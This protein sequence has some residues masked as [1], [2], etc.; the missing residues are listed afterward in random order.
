MLL[1][2]RV[3]ASAGGGGRW[4]VTLIEEGTSKRGF[5]TYPAATLREAVDG[6]LFEMRPCLLYPKLDARGQRIGEDHQGQL[7]A[8]GR[9]AMNQVGHYEGVRWVEG[10]N[11]RPGRVEGTLV[12]A[13]GDTDADALNQKL[14]RLEESGGLD[15]LGLSID[16]DADLTPNGAVAR[17]YEI[18]SVDVVTKPGMGGAFSHRIAASTSGARSM[19]LIA[20]IR[21]RYPRLLEGYSGPELE[22]S[23][24][25]H[26]ARQ[27]RESEEA[28]E[29][30]LELHPA[31]NR[32]AVR[33]R[34]TEDVADVLSLLDE[35]QMLISIVREQMQQAA[36]A[37][38]AAAAEAPSSA[39]APAPAAEPAGEPANVTEAAER[40]RRQEERLR[41]LESRESIRAFEAAARRANL[42]Q[43]SINRIRRERE[44]Q[45]LE[46]AQITRLVESEA[47]SV[48]ALL[49]ERGGHRAV[50]IVRESRERL[51]E[52]LAHLFAPNRCPRPADSTFE[53]HGFSLHRFTEAAWG[54]DLRRL[55]EG[56]S[57]RRRLRE[58]VDQTN[59]DQVYADALN[60]AVNA[61]YQGDPQMGDQ[62]WRQIAAIAP[63]S[64]F[65][66]HKD[67][68]LGNYGTLPSVAKRSPYGALST[69]TDRQETWA[70]GKYGGTE[71]IAWEDMVDDNLGVWQEMVR[72]MGLA[73]RE[74]LND[75]VF[76][77][78]R[79]A[80]MPTMSDG[81]A[82]CDSG[83]SPANAG[84]SVLSNDATGWA[85]LMAAATAMMGHTG[86]G[87]KPKGIK[88]STLVIPKEK[89]HIAGGLLSDFA[90]NAQAADFPGRQGLQILGVVLRNVVIDLYTSNTTDWFVMAD[91][92]DAPVLKVAFLNGREEPELFFDDNANVSTMFTQDVIRAKIRHV[93]SAWASDW[94]GIHGNDAAS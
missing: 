81:N 25:T 13:L 58:S 22:A 88:P 19:R 3:L 44:G 5:P 77:L 4:R 16:A 75:A 27:L 78:I 32:D 18:S 9:G 24:A 51:V 29:C 37:A 89:A 10:R 45:V 56:Q 7:S 48:D 66:T 38:I 28:R 35:A 91:P 64:D 47:A 72:R 71:D 20:Y 42:P 40:S 62:A 39:P 93:W 15:S 92:G 11:G 33:A 84:T 76:S 21:D 87:G 46:P 49:R 12:L 31:E 83:R 74:T 70:L 86:G 69:P 67:V 90:A 68:T 41:V 73:A 14:T 85:N 1:R 30:A 80:T 61:T 63:A 60:I 6:G 17:F 8:V 52:T 26:I 43:A 34:L 55:Q 57:A 23:V 2:G 53:R 59:F 79:F 50:S 36:G 54:V 65:R 94:V 82:L